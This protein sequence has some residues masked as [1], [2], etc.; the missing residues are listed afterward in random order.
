MAIRNNILR[1]L[2]EDDYASI[3]ANLTSHR[4]SLKDDLYHSGEQISHVYFPMS[5]YASVVVTGEGG[6]AELSMIGREGVVGATL[7]LGD[8]LSPFDVFI[9]ADGDAL[10]MTAEDFREALARSEALRDLMGRYCQVLLIQA[11]ESIRASARAQLDQ[12][13]ARWLLMSHDRLNSDTLP[14]VHQF[15]ALMLGVRRA[16]V[17]VA[18]HELEGKGLLKAERGAVTILDLDGLVEYAGGF[19][20]ASERQ[21]ARLIG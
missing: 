7:A 16:G 2:G 11:G 15:M 8:P 20:G 14:V 3:T 4:F 12:R 10:R 18:L 13:L 5:G 21:Y 9:Q 17:T 1:L 19:Y 6:N